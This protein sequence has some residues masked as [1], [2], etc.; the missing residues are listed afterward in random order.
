[1]HRPVG[2]AVKRLGIKM[3]DEEGRAPRKGPESTS[4]GKSVDFINGNMC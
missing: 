4:V 2:R 1:M 3:M